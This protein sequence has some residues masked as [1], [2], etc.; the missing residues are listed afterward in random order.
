MKL[1]LSLD[2]SLIKHMKAQKT[3]QLKLFSLNLV[4]LD[5]GRKNLNRWIINYLKII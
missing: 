3:A 1:N 2:N 5:L 4:K